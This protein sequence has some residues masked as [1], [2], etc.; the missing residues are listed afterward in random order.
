MSGMPDKPKVPAADQ[1][2]RILSFLARQRGGVPAATISKNLGIPR[3]S[4]YHL[5][6]ALSRHG[7]VV[8]GDRLWALGVAAHDLGSGF[9][10]QQPLALVGRSLVARLSDQLGENC[11]LAVLNGRDVVYVIEER[12]SGKPSLVSDVGVR[13]PAHLTASG[14]AMLS[15]LS[16][17]QVLA[18]YPDDSALTSRGEARQTRIELRDELRKTRERGYAIED[19]EITS[20]LY[21][22]AVPVLDRSGWPIASVAT[23]F[24]ASQNV[25]PAPLVEKLKQ[26]A[27]EISRRLRA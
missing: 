13:L 7:F 21:S 9:A 25:A 19:G 8:N 3:S 15:V 4:V 22:L 14:R 2:A 16:R 10:R 26:A 24:A 1:V 20:G 18:I 23:T 17:E 12:A 27:G 6:S 5:L 11:H